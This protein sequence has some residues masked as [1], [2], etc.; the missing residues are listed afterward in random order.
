MASKR[1]GAAPSIRRRGSLPAWPAMFSMVLAVAC[2]A[3]DELEHHAG[4]KLGLPPGVDAVRLRGDTVVSVGML[5]NGMYLAITANHL[6]ISDRGGDPFMHVIDL[7]GD[8]LI[9][10]FGRLG[11]GPGDFG[12][13][14]KL[15]V[16]PGDEGA[17]WAYDAVNRRLTRFVGSPVDSLVS[18]RL[19]GLQLAH[20]WSLVWQSDEYLIGVGD[21]DTNRVVRVDSALAVNELIAVPFIGPDS[22]PMEIRRV[23]ATAY[24]ICM[25]PTGAEFGIVYQAAGRIEIYD[26][27][28]HFRRLADVPFPSN[29]EWFVATD[30]RLWFNQDWYYYIG[31]AATDKYLYGLFVGESTRP[32]NYSAVQVHQFNWEGKLLGVFELEAPARVIAVT[33]DDQSIYAVGYG[34]SEVIRYQLPGMSQVQPLIRVP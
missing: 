15:S 22:A 6:W 18:S 26:Q 2:A 23:M 7:Y 8:S 28:G 21:M 4:R 11:E 13:A 1:M 30:G 3:S 32:S 27:S 33:V 16:R 20:V 9:R 17:V 24:D 25:Q 10:S 12:E 31:C 34:A 5:T 29:G 19:S 14:P